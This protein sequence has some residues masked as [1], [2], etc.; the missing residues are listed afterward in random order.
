MKEQKK[1]YPIRFKE[2]T[3]EYPWGNETFSL[4]DL[5]AVD[6]VA[7]NGWLAGNAFSDIME[8]YLERVGGEDVYKYYGRQFP[9]SVSYLDINGVFPARCHPDDEAAGQRY[10][11]L[12]KRVFWRV[13]E[14]APDARLYIGFSRDM[15]ASDFY[16]SVLSGTLRETLNVHVPVAGESFCIVPGTVYAAEGR[17]KIL[18]VSESSLVAFILEDQAEA[19]QAGENAAEALDLINLGRTDF[20][21]AMCPAG[22]QDAGSQDAGC[23]DVGSQDAGSAAGDGISAEGCTELLSS[24]EFSVNGIRV[25]EPLKMTSGDSFTVLVC[26]QGGISVQVKGRKEGGTASMDNYSLHKGE[27]LLVPAD[28]EEFFLVTVERG[29]EVLSVFMDRHEDVDSYIN[30]DTA[31]YLEGE[32]YEGVEDMEDE[33]A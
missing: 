33:E 15:S 32:D 12:G 17:M 30:P 1:L 2:E 7:D 21:Q 3:L 6:S 23:Q 19:L 10:D 8:T 4:A 13:L 9:V 16:A 27:S 5:G 18:E 20:A 28:V 24:P 11:A 31:P 29:A 25:S 22:S 26:T 14:A